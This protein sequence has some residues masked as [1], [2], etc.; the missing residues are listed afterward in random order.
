M[1][2]HCS[3]VF[4]DGSNCVRVDFQQFYRPLADADAVF[5]EEVDQLLAIDKRDRGGSRSEGGILGALREP[6]RCNDRSP[7]C[8]EAVKRASKCI[9]ILSL[10]RATVALG[11]NDLADRGDADLNV[12]RRRLPRHRLTGM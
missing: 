1:R 2:G 7:N 9:E 4:I 11:L 10:Y 3:I 5:D 12:R 8:V 6:R